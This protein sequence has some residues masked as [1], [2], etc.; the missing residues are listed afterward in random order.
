MTAAAL[1]DRYGRRPGALGALSTSGA[2]ASLIADRCEALGV[3]AGGPVARDPRR[4]STAHKMFSRIGN[5]LDLGIFGGMRRSAEVPA[6]LMADPGVSRRAGAG[7]FD[8][9]VAGRPVSRRMAAARENSG[10]PL[11]IVSPGGMPEAERGHLRSAG[12]GRVH[13]DGH[14]AGGHRRAVDPGA[15]PCGGR[16]QNPPSAVRRGQ[17]PRSLPDRAADEAGESFASA[18]P[19]VRRAGRVP[20]VECASVR[21]RCRRAR[22]SAS[23]SR[24][25]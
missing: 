10:R 21:Y 8:E 22:R 14:R 9:P 15:R 13:R 19:K 25:C 3:P 17:P 7:A 6:L 23:A 24:W 12:H 11:L 5:P 2:G 18:R 20:T 16:A 4:R 1:L